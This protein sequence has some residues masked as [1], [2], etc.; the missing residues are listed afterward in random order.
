MPIQRGVDKWKL[1]KWFNI[2][3][4]KLFNEVEITE[5][6]ANDEK[7]VGRNIIIG[8]ELLTGNPAHAYTNVKLKVVN[9]NGDRAITQL[10]RLELVGSYIK[11]FVRRY[12]SISSA[13][14]P[15]VSKDNKNAVV[16][17][18]A[19]TR[20]K[21]TSSKIKGI[22]QEMSNFTKEYFKNNDL[23]SIIKAIIEGK[24]QAEMG[25]KVRYV[26]DLS[27]LEVRKLEIKS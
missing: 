19:V 21:S 18:I 9:V 14:L 17:L 13:V 8:L 2:I 6:P 11:S 4:P 1:K 15:V 25:A 7:I 22:R 10:V 16:K 23:D 12:K 24:F 27:K 26:A 3:A 5:M 20:S